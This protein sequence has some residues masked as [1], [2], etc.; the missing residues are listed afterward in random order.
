MVQWFNMLSF[1]LLIGLIMIYSS[2]SEGICTICKNGFEDGD[3]AIH[4]REKSAHGFNNAS[5]QRGDSA[6]VAAGCKVQ[7]NCRK[8]HINSKYIGN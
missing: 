7:S 8:K 5:I 3:D 4:I 2:V 6:V 1:D